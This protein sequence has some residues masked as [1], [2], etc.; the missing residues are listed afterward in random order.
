MREASCI[1]VI[2]GMRPI[3]DDK[4]LHMLKQSTRC[5]KTFSLVTI[6]LIECFLE[7][8]SS[9]LELDMYERKSVDEYRHIIAIGSLTIVSSVLVDDLESIIVY[10]SFVD[11]VNIFL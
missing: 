2:L 1:T 11:E 4:E 9:P 5:P 8:D 6:D 3:G 7:S 10:I